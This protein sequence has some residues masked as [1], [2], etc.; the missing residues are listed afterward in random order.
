[1]T[2]SNMIN[3]LIFK[4]DT[5]FSTYNRGVSMFRFLYCLFLGGGVDIEQQSLTHHYP[6]WVRGCDGYD[7][8][9]VGFASMYVTSVYCH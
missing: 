7:H 8:M 9:V 3:Q 4:N 1:M 5:K 2:Q 6:D